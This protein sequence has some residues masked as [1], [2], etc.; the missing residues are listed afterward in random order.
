L[1]AQHRERKQSIKEKLLLLLVILVLG[2]GLAYAAYGI[3]TFTAASWYPNRSSVKDISFE[4]ERLSHSSGVPKGACLRI[5]GSIVTEDQ[6]N[7]VDSW[8]RRQ[9]WE[10]LYFQ[11]NRV[12]LWQSRPVLHLGLAEMDSLRRAFFCAAAD[13]KGTEISTDTILCIRW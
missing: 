11:S 4:I 12:G 6:T 7:D 13:H 8:Y 5:S 3:L 10:D 2:V 1:G 9:G